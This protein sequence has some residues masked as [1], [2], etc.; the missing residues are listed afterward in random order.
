MTST[1][2]S[3]KEQKQIDKFANAVEGLISK[4]NKRCEK[5]K[6]KM[7]HSSPILVF[8]LKE[9]KKVGVEFTPNHVVC[10]PCDASRAGGFAPNLGK[11]VLCENMLVDKSHLEDTLAHEFVHAYD[12]ATINLNWNNKR[13]LAC[14][15][16]RAANLSGE[17]R[18]TKE[19]RR[20]YLGLAKQQQSCVK[21]RAILGLLQGGCKTRQE[22]EEAVRSVWDSCFYDNTPF[23]EVY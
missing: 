22:A 9:L 10:T 12:H 3:E 17:C 6:S 2:V 21:R 15:E 19:V 11:V 16:I 18:F 20:G 7:L 8:M 13:H 14:S 4:D 1:P 5:W 23:D